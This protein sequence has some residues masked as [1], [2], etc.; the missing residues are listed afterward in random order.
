MIDMITA[1][2]AH[3]FLNFIISVGIGLT[4]GLER[5]VNIRNAEKMAGM[6][7][8]MLVSVLAF[9]SSLYYLQTPI[10]WIGAFTATICFALA[11]FIIGNIVRAGSRPMGMTS[12][13]ALPITF[14]VASLPN[15]GAPFWIIATIMF[16]ILMVLGL[17]VR[18]YQFV[19]TIERH[20]IIDF[21]VLIGIAVSITP[22]IPAEARLPIPLI[23]IIN[24]VATVTYQYVMLASLWKVVVMVS[25]MSFIAHFVTKYTKGRNALLMA[26][27]LGGMVSSLGTVLMLLRNHKKTNEDGVETT[28]TLTRDELFLGF[29]ATSTGAI[30]RCLVILRTTI[31]Y[32]LF[33]QYMFP[34][35][36]S[37]MLFVSI[38]LYSFSSH[39][40]VATDMRMS[41][42]PL[43][44]IFIFKFSGMLAALIVLMT[45]VTH[46]LGNAA[47]IPASFL[48]GII[49]S[50]AAV[51]SVGAAMLQENALDAWTAGVA[52]IAAILGSLFGKLF[53][54]TKHIGIKQSLPFILATL[55]LGIISL[56]TLWISFSSPS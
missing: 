10:A 14:L 36:A 46:Y 8:F 20:E 34:L 49:S 35:T 53:L 40:N 47:I 12:M 27:F 32:D 31:G 50:A 22:L 16:A 55:G 51:T 2:T 17:K 13:L 4:V 7:D 26:S 38:S 48:S 19:S 24:G 54:I 29:A 43:P 1:S 6:R 9:V 37:L 30:L 41:Q 18:I 33:A 23:D 45:L 28:R 44:F 39:P 52:I 11:T 5:T 3:L 56:L 21:A 25:L 42:R 15:F